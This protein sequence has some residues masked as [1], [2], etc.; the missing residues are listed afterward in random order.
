MTM[1]DH[2]QVQPSTFNPLLSDGL[3]AYSQ[4]TNFSRLP[5]H[6]STTI[7]HGLRPSVLKFEAASEPASYL[8]LARKRLAE[9][10]PSNSTA[11]QSYILISCDIATDEIRVK[12][13]KANHRPD[14]HKRHQR[15][16]HSVGRHRQGTSRA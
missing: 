1:G 16:H 3:I 9:W 4:S 11:T 6:F 8:K 14:R 7:N 10:E 13:S 5:S 12:S 2:M 15:F